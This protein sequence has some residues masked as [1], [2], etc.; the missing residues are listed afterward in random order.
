M[1]KITEAYTPDSTEDTTVFT[2]KDTDSSAT[3][4]LNTNGFRYDIWKLNINEAATYSYETPEVLDDVLF[5]L[6]SDP[7]GYLD[8]FSAIEEAE[9]GFEDLRYTYE[10][11]YLQ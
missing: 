5:E 8:T 9:V 7:T 6:I 3:Y 2:L 10:Q 1:I 4:E 11:T